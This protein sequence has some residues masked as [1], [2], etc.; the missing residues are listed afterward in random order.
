M[1]VLVSILIIHYISDYIFQTRWIAENKSKSWMT[2]L[3]HAYLYSIPFLLLPTDSVMFCRLCMLHF[4]TDLVTSRLSA[5]YYK[6]D[7]LKMFWI[8][9]GLDQLL[10][11]FQLLYIYKDII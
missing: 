7:N 3:F 2:C 11:I 10:H 5:N 8:I 1:S 4:F 6:A 9:I